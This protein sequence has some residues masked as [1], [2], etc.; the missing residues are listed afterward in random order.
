MKKL[1]FLIA[2]SLFVFS[3]LYAAEGLTER[4][5]LNKDN[6]E[7][8]IKEIKN[9]AGFKTLDKKEFK[10]LKKEFKKELRQKRSIKENIS[11]MLLFGALLLVGG[12]LLYLIVTG[13]P[14]I[15]IAVMIVG[16]LLLIYGALTKFF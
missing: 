2:A 15:G 16:V 7:Q 6:S 1:L 12:L 11:N 13:A 9:H 5:T 10:K 14:W 8:T 4:S 3:G